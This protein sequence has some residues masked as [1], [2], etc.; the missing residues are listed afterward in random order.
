MRQGRSRGGVDAQGPGRYAEDGTA[1][2]DEPRGAWFPLTEIRDELEVQTEDVGARWWLAGVLSTLASQNGVAY[3]RFV[4]SSRDDTGPRYESD[5]FPR[6]RGVFDD[7]PPEEQWAPGV[8]A[9]FEALDEQLRAHG[10][11]RQGPVGRR[12]QRRRPDWARR[13][14]AARAAPTG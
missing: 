8:A 11:C 1:W 10:W 14:D 2:Y 4:A 7:P 3:T 12:Y 5:T 6:L 9:A 13:I